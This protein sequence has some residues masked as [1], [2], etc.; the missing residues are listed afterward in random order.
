MAFDINLIKLHKHIFCK[1][2]K[3]FYSACFTETWYTESYSIQI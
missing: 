1:S 2:S 3:T